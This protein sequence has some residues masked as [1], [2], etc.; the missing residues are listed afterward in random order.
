MDGDGGVNNAV[1]ETL[2]E[3]KKGA[4]AKSQEDQMNASAVL[5]VIRIV[6]CQ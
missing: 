1:L 2:C 6:L 4:E 3:N 5:D